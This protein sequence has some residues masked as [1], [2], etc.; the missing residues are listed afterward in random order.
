MKEDLVYRKLARRERRVSQYDISQHPFMEN[1][2]LSWEA[3]NTDMYSTERSWKEVDSILDEN[4][5]ERVDL[6]PYMQESP[7]VCVTTDRI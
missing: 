6:R 7:Y 3:F 2:K 5:D 4:M 1:N